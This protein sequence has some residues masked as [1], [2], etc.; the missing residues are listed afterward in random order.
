MSVDGLFGQEMP[1]DVWIGAQ[2]GGDRPGRC[3]W[4]CG[5]AVQ[6]VD[7]NSVN[8]CVGQIETFQKKAQWRLPGQRFID[9]MHVEK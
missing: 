3:S 9:V 6:Y 8:V 4:F 1:N 7:V 5:Q 2:S